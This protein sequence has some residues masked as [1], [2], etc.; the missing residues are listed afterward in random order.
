MTNRAWRAQETFGADPT[1]TDA[2][3]P[4][5]TNSI[6]PTAPAPRSRGSSPNSGRVD[7]KRRHGH[8]RRRRPCCAAGTGARTSQNRGTA[9]AVSDRRADR[10]R[11]GGQ[12]PGA[13]RT[14]RRSARRS[15]VLKRHFGRIDPEWGQVNRIRR[16]KL[17]LPIDGGPDI[18]R[19]VYGEPQ[20]D[21]T[22]T[23]VAGDTFIM[24]VTWD[25]AGQLSVPKASTSSAPPPSMPPRRT[26]PTRRRC[27][28]R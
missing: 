1:I 21:G 27:S 28:S 23:A 22:L 15:T 9:L 25:Q 6:S 8:R 24:F 10:R 5:T 3:L 13:G 14:L 4:A 7:P 18:Y 20:P 2:S 16:G 17:D 26:T 12:A 19:A 11:L